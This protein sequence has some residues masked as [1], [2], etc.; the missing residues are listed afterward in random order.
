MRP[1]RSSGSPNSP[2]PCPASRP[3]RAHP[4]GRSQPGTSSATPATGSS[5]SAWRHRHATLTPPSRSPAASPT[6]SAGEPAGQIT[7]TLT[8]AGHPDP[9]VYLVPPPARSLRSLPGGTTA[10]EAH[11]SRDHTRAE[12][13]SPGDIAQ[14]AARHGQPRPP[15]RAA[16]RP[17]RNARHR[18]HRHPRHDTGHRHAGHQPRQWHRPAAGRRTTDTGGHHATSTVSHLAATGGNCSRRPARPGPRR[19]EARSQARPGQPGPPRQPAR[20]RYAAAARA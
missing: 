18:Q 3:S 6:R 12:D 17:G 7:L 19:V 8:R 20:R 2:P 10:T 4:P 1:Q 16:R 11:T 15:R 5:R 13:D 14:P 9:V